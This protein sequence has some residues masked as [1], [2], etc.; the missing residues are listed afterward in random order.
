M[1]ILRP[2]LRDKRTFG[3]SLSSHQVDVL[4]LF[5]VIVLYAACLKMPVRLA[6][7]PFVCPTGYQ[8]LY[9][10]DSLVWLRFNISEF[11]PGVNCIFTRFAC[12]SVQVPWRETS[13]VRSQNVTSVTNTLLSRVLEAPT[14]RYKSLRDEGPDSI[15]R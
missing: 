3:K 15:T 11:Y 6:V 12:F 14:I 1:I 8:I 9:A 7:C 5:P 13:L 4:R 10:A 2:A